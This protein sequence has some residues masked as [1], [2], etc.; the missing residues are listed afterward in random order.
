M[1]DIS[2]E[3]ECYRSQ[4]EGGGEVLSQTMQDERDDN[5]DDHDHDAHPSRVEG[6]IGGHMRPFVV[7]DTAG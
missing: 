7:I 6:E 5:H 3:S 4:Y 1:R 2:G